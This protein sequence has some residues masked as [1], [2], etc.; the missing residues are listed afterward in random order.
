M[1]LKSD[2]ERQRINHKRFIEM[3][4]NYRRDWYAT[5]RDGILAHINEVNRSSKVRVI[6]YYG[7]RCVKCGNADARCLELHH[8]NG[9]G[10]THRIR[11]TGG[12]SRQ[13]YK[14]IELEGFPD[15]LEVIC[16]NC[17]KILH[18]KY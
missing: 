18:C 15:G 16:A 12:A 5:H 13:I 4:P 11:L 1:L 17:H 6:S 8:I 10:L 9:C 14:K 3:H 2:K 7:G